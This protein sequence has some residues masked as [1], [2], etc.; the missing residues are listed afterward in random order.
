MLRLILIII[1]GVLAL[2]FFGISLRGIVNSPIGQENIQFVWQLVQEG[3]TY[4]AN[5]FTAIA[6]MRHA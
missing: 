5:F 4:V 6:S 3:W 2:S 1:I